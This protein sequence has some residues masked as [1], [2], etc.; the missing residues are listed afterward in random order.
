MANN[1]VNELWD[2]KIGELFPGKRRGGGD[3]LDTRFTCG[4][5]ASRHTQNSNAWADLRST[6]KVRNRGQG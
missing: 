4:N 6:G 5:L 1:L 3:G 2:A